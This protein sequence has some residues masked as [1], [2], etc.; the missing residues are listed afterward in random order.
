MQSKVM[1]PTF[2]RFYSDEAKKSPFL[3]S[4]VIVLGGLVLL[5]LI[6]LALTLA[7]PAGAAPNSTLTLT[8]NNTADVPMPT[9]ATGNAKRQKATASARCAPPLW[10][11][12]LRQA[13]TRLI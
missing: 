10:R 9:P 1:Q 2:T 5:A 13:R 12:M 6:T 11:Q 4:K 8:V 7:V 3:S